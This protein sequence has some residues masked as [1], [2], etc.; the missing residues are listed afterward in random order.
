MDG[1]NSSEEP[2]KDVN[3]FRLFFKQIGVQIENSLLRGVI[4]PSTSQFIW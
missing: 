4:F 3:F 1:D 2:T